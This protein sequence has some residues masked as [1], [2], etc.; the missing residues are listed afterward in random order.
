MKIVETDVLV[1]GGGGS[2]MAAAISA[3][4]NGARVV[5]LE[6]TPRL[7]GT[8]GMSVGSI[9]ASGT[10]HQKRLG[11]VDGPQQHFEDMGKFLRELD[12]RE[13]KQLRKILVDN[14][15][16]TLDWLMGFG[17]RFFGPSEEPPHRVARMHN[18]LPSARA[19]PILLGKQCQRCGVQVHTATP[20]ISIIMKDNDVL[21]A[22]AKIDGELVEVRARGGT[23]LATGDF[24]ASTSLKQ[25]YCS[26]VANVNAYNPASTGDGHVL[27]E[28]LGGT[29]L[30]GDVS[31][32]PRMRFTPK[33]DLTLFQRMPPWRWLMGLM[34]LALET[35]PMK[36][37]RPIMISFMTS[38]SSPEPGLLR[39]GAI[40]VNQMGQRFCDELN[41]P[42]YHIAAQPGKACYMVFDDDVANK[43][44]TWPNFV[45]TAPGI[46]YA[47]VSDYRK[48]RP[49]IYHTA[50][51]LE[52]LASA[53]GM[54]PGSLSQ[55]V[56][57][58]NDALA[59]NPNGRPAV[60]RG[61]F[62]AFGPVSAW[63][64]ITEGGLA[65]NADHEVLERMASQS[66]GFMRWV[67]WGR[68][69]LS[70]QATDIILD[71][72]LPPGGVP[73]NALPR[74]ALYRRLF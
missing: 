69:A 1:I 18:V 24:S 14:V 45:S 29:T 66:G 13:N 12:P 37:F 10:P 50:S 53:L 41:A 22:V 32:G 46:A 51:T 42:E 40:M 31:R 39:A 52:E 73:G 49:D 20:V 43:F 70:S 61:P 11:I 72:P 65:V 59:A 26:R 57:T 28:A 30:N 48:S 38:A 74:G 27:A 25:V 19:Y 33:T 44:E 15:S 3:A 54:P 21:G 58:H 71:G 17:L 55:T 4:E 56:L 23:I 64:V 5:L 7:G 16:S 47:Y 8:T 34:K 63:V 62:H 35:L 2:G 68:A 6:K 9:T 60:K 36:L 67:Q